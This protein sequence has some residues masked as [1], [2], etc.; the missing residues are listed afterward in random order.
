VVL[1]EYPYTDQL[2]HLATLA[3]AASVVGAKAALES[4]AEHLRAGVL[5]V[6][7][8]DDESAEAAELAALVYKQSRARAKGQPE[9]VLASTELLL[10]LIARGYAEQLSA[11]LS[12]SKIAPPLYLRAAARG[13]AAGADLPHRFW[14]REQ[15]PAIDWLCAGDTVTVRNPMLG[16]DVK[17]HSAMRKGLC[18]IFLGSFVLVRKQGG[19]PQRVAKLVGLVDG[20]SCILQACVWH[21]LP[22]RLLELTPESEY[23]IV[24][25]VQIIGP[26]LV[27]NESVVEKR[28]GRAAATDQ[29]WFPMDPL[30]LDLRHCVF[31]LSESSSSR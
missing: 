31:Q 15:Q 17:S 14:Q 11:P 9:V 2:R 22:S 7:D 28:F 1:R 30:A 26:A 16:A 8:A 19:I 20:K 13:S 23:F 27:L 29:K 24:K 25:P 10:Q 6:L 3:G 21:V 12:Q 18:S 5:V 4:P